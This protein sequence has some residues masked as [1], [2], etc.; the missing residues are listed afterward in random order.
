MAGGRGARASDGLLEREVGGSRGAGTAD[1]STK[2]GNAEV[3]GGGR[4]FADSRGDGAQAEGTQP[5]GRG[6]DVHAEEVGLQGPAS[7]VQRPG[8]DRGGDAGRGRNYLEVEPLIGFFV[9][10]LAI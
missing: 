1:R 10:M 8:A 3:R 6:D 2:T 9:N 4:G 5:A 7:Q